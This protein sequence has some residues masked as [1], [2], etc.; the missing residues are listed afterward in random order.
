MSLYNVFDIAGSGMSAQN[1]R[2]NTTASNISNANSISSSQDKVYRARHPVFAAELNKAA[3]ANPN[4]LSS[5]VGVKVLGIVESD[6]PLQVEYN[7]NHPSADKDGY[8]YKPNVNV[9][10]EMTNMISASR[11]YQTNVQVA[12]AAKQMLSKTLLL[13]QR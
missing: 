1:V 12:D 5:S 4:T 7:P 9:V 10:E 13:G 8:I 3:A 11:S 2:L 6:K